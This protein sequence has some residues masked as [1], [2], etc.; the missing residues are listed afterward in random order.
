MAIKKSMTRRWMLYGFSVIA[1]VLL[2]VGCVLSV[3]VYT[4]YHRGVASL[5]EERAAL[6][7]RSAVFETV[8]AETW[9][10]TAFV[11]VGSFESKEQMELQVLSETGAVLASS[12]GF[13]PLGTDAVTDFTAAQ[14]ANGTLCHDTRNG[15]DEH[16]MALTVLETAQDGTTIGALRYVVSMRLIDRQIRLAAITIGGAVLLV[17]LFMAL[18][19]FYF[20]RSIVQPVEDIGRAA[21]RIAKGEY[22][23]RIKKYNN[24]ELGELCDTINYMAGEIER[25]EQLKNDFISSVSHE[26]RTPLT[27]IRG[28]SETLREVGGNDS[29]LVEKGME[30]ISQETDRLAGMVEELLDF[31]RMQNGKLTLRFETV[32]LV[33]LLEETVFLFR[34][35]ADKKGVFLRLA[36]KGKLPVVSGDGDRLKQV[37][38]N[39]LDNA[40]KYS[41]A[42]DTVRVDYATI[43][44][45]VQIV[46]GDTGKGIAAED[47]PRVTQK[48]YKADLTRPGSGIGLAVADEIVRGHGGTME[49]DSK[50]AVG[51]GIIITLPIRKD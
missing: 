27:A 39:V 24:D 45:S 5:L 20:I 23:Y 35:R 15:T 22:A 19:S 29:A 30:I 44:K 38:I 42:G 14:A 36:G 4:Y 13:M 43:G 41:D 48:F 50:P 47:L 9:K 49:I 12:T 32:D 34:D 26:L 6:Y 28:W 17:L 46:V 1:A 16:I 8:S 51:T 2:A 31:S 11:L 3:L 10:D 40:I 18:V 33:G 7:R 21:R 25:A 37:F